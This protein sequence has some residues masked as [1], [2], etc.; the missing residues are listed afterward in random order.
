M[1]MMNMMQIGNGS[2][3]NLNG[4]QYGNM[5]NQQQFGQ[6]N[7]NMN[8][9]AN[10]QMNQYLHQQQPQNF[11]M[12]QQMQHPGNGSFRMQYNQYGNQTPSPG[13]SPE[14]GSSSSKW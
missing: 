12:Q 14:P 5:A 2:N 11:M 3:V 4:N 7:M 10:H 13:H 1:M 8:G 6:Q 9:N